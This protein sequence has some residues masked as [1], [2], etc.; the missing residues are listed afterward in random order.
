MWHDG[1]PCMFGGRFF[2]THIFLLRNL[3]MNVKP[4]SF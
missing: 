3:L 4:L 1:G 2:S